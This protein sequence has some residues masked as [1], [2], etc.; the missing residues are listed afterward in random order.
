LIGLTEAS[1]DAGRLAVAELDERGIAWRAGG[2]LTGCD[3]VVDVSGEPAVGSVDAAVAM[4][5]AYLDRCADPAHLERVYERHAT[6]PVLVVPGCAPEAVLGDLAAA[7]AVNDLDRDIDEVVVAY[8]FGGT[9]PRFATPGRWPRRRRIRFPDGP[10]TGVEVLWGERV[11]VPRWLPSG[12]ATTVVTVTE[13]NATLLRVGGLL[14]PLS[15][16]LPNPVPA[17]ARQSGFRLLAECRAGTRRAAV[18]VEVTGGPELAARV[19]VEAALQAGG[20]G[21]LTPAQAL[22][23]E[24]FLQSLSGSD[25]T[26]QRVDSRP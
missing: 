11:R 1:G 14:D 19:L 9:V 10:V 4:G 12:R 25:L 13:L 2:D 18:L 5:A 24:P 6:A 17:A 26:W 21:A 20:A 23:P 16:L 8:D 15:R 22:D 7:V 3:V